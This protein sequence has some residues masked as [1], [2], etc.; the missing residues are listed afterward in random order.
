MLEMATLG[1]APENGCSALG[2][3]LLARLLNP[4]FIGSRELGL[5]W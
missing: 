2:M 5:R 1:E 4:S 3:K